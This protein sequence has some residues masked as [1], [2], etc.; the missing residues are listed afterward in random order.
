M[1]PIPRLFVGWKTDAGYTSC[2]GL[3]SGT[4]FIASGQQKGFAVGFWGIGFSIFLPPVRSYGMFGYALYARAS[5]EYMEY[6]PPNNPPEITQTDPVDGQEMV[7]VATSELRFS[8][9]DIDGDR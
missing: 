5:A 4:G 8:I 6:Y 7:P 2:G 1:A 3:V 9:E